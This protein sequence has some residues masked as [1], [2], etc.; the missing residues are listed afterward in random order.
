[1][2]PG[3][4]DPAFPGQEWTEITAGNAPA[5]RRFL[6]SAGPFTLQAGAVNKITIGV[7]WARA[8]SGGQEASVTLVKVYDR[9]AQALFDNNFNILN[10]PDA[11]D[12]DIQELDKQLVFTLSNS[13]IS[14]IIVP[15]ML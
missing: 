3:T 11:P 9:E 14:K 5:D 7:V 13:G 10:G 8:N 4:T 12:L 2:F 6:Q 1:M 15:T